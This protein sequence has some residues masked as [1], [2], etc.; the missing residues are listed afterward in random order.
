VV[1][2]ESGLSELAPVKS[3]HPPA[4]TALRRANLNRAEAAFQAPQAI[5]Q[6]SA[7]SSET[8]LSGNSQIST[9]LSALAG[10]P[11]SGDLSTAQSAFAPR[12][13]DLK[14]SARR[15]RSTRPPRLRNPCNWSN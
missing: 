8:T 15:H 12:R 3:P 10:V 14:S 7:M 9:N 2:G 4:K 11:S 6:N 5:L 13:G 1:C